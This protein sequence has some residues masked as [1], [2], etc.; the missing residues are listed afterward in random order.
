ML[1]WVCDSDIK[2]P[3]RCMILLRKFIFLLIYAMS[4]LCLP[5]FLLCICVLY[6]ADIDIVLIF[7]V[8][9]LVSIIPLILFHTN[10]NNF[11]RHFISYIQKNFNTTGRASRLEYWRFTVLYLFFIL[12]FLC[13][14][15]IVESTIEGNKLLAVGRTLYR[16]SIFSSQGLAILLGVLCTLLFPARVSVSIRRYHDCNQSGWWFLLHC[17][18]ACLIITHFYVLV[19]TFS[20]F[21]DNRLTEDRLIF[22]LISSIVLYILLGIKKGTQGIN[23]Y[24]EAPHREYIKEI[25]KDT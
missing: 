11:Q 9:F 18:L 24:G 15:L 6:G 17:V 22:F 25:N 7:C 23:Q 13:V 3:K 16:F 8:C 10:K 4:A 19:V 1:G 20:L 14:S 21:S 5:F 12:M 2:K